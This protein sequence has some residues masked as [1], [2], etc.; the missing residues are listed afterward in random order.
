MFDTISNSIRDSVPFLNVQFLLPYK[1]HVDGCLV[2]SSLSPPHP[3]NYQR[4]ISEI[5]FVALN[6][7]NL[8][9]CWTLALDSSNEFVSL[10]PDFA[11]ANGGLCQ[12]AIRSAV[13]SAE[14]KRLLLTDGASLLYLDVGVSREGVSLPDLTSLGVTRSLPASALHAV[15]V[16]GGQVL[17]LCVPLVPALPAH[18][19]PVVDGQ[20]SLAVVDLTQGV[21]HRLSEPSLLNTAVQSAQF[22]H[23]SLRSTNHAKV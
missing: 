13:F 1:P 6:S 20:N 4:A 21:L 8:A 3:Q 15:A 9:I 18:L 23:L 16:R 7:Q 10:T 22:R 12:S 19:V 11:F 2:A 5:Q 14:L 17:D